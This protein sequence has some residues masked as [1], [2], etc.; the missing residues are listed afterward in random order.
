MAA[1]DIRRA[2]HFTGAIHG[3]VVVTP[4]DDA[5]LVNGEGA[6]PTNLLLAEEGAV[7]VEDVFGNE[8]TFPAGGLAVGVFH[9][10]K[11]KKVLDTGTDNITIIV[12][13]DG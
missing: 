1:S 3:M 13:W 10:L 6:N 7:A 8:I 12:G 9:R 2:R 4:D 11:I 5:E